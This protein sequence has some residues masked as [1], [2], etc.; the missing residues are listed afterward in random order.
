[1]SAGKALT[2]SSSVTPLS[3][4]VM[5][6]IIT[7]YLLFIRK[8]RSH[9]HLHYAKLCSYSYLIF[10]L[11]KQIEDQLIAEL[12]DVEST[13]SSVNITTQIYRFNVYSYKQFP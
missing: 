7:E 8:F 1:M 2:V 5:T 9:F 4:T 3:T 13:K 12:A 11:L 10:I 6:A